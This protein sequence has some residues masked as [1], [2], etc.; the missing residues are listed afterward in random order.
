MGRAMI[1]PLPYTMS[2]LVE[3]QRCLVAVHKLMLI[4]HESLVPGKLGMTL[5]S[6][7]D[8]LDSLLCWAISTAEASD[9]A[10]LI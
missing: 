8:D 10:P 3:L 9:H 7:F 5:Q 4:H 2:Q 1:T 6:V